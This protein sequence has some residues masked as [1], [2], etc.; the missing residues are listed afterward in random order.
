MATRPARRR[1]FR[2]VLLAALAAPLAMTAR[3][4]V[5]WEELAA[6]PAPPDGLRQAYADES[7]LQFGVL[8]LPPGPGPHPVA[9]VIHGGCWES[10]YD[11]RHIEPASAALTEA[12]V[13]TWTLEYRR[14]GDKGGGWP[15]TLLDVARGVDHL[16]VLAAE[17][18][19]DLARVVLVGHS[20]GGHLALWAAGRARLP[21][22]SELRTGEPLPVRGVVALAAISDLR[23]YALGD[24]SCNRSAEKLIGGGERRYGDRY[25]QASPLE[26]APLGV[27]VRL[28]H[29]TD[30]FIVPLSQSRRFATQEGEGN[31]DVDLAIL[32]G[33]GHF[34]LVAPFA[35][36]WREVQQRVLELAWR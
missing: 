22:G 21:E 32:P 2:T 18:P 11:L 12:G 34:D 6:Q 27:A 23:R 25:A 24:D 29:G 3:G 36:A 10:E 8:R 26:L 17:Q 15:G 1:T 31:R 4:A 33:V 16:R 5:T 28:V 9:V 20:A 7:P 30:D 13:A 35:P 19:L 14:L